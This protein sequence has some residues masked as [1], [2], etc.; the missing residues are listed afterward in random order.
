MPSA[1]HFLD[2]DG[3]LLF[4]WIAAGCLDVV[5]CFPEVRGSVNKLDGFSQSPE[6]GIGIKLVVRDHLGPVNAGERPIEGIFQQA[7][8][9]DC[10]RSLDL[11]DQGAEI[12]Q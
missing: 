3:H 1:D 7:G 10:Q 2:N 8:R 12:T 9:S 6:T 11:L 5:A 4:A